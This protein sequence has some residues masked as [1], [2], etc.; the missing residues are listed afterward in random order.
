VGKTARVEWPSSTLRTTS[1]CCPLNVAYPKAVLR[2]PA[3]TSSVSPASGGGSKGGRSL[4]RCR[5]LLM[6]GWMVGV[7]LG[8]RGAASASLPLPSGIACRHRQ[9][10][11]FCSG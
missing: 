5:L 4:D 8:A 9:Y 1:S 11:K 10:S 7:G 2:Q 3:S 6:L